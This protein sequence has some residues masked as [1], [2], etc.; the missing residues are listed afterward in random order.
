M[1]SIGQNLNAVIRYFISMICMFVSVLFATLASARVI[2][3]PH[4]VVD[5]MTLFYLGIAILAAVYSHDTK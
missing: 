1:S 4:R 3:T 5:N 2:Y